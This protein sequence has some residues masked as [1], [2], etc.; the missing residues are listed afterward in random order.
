MS[1]DLQCEL[2]RLEHEDPDVQGASASLDAVYD[3]LKGRLPSSLVRD[4]YDLE[5]PYEVVLSDDS[6]PGD[7]G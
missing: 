1:R 4:I 5:R 3:H 6:E 2:D 7:L